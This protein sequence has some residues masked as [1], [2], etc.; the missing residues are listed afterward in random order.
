MKLSV[1]VQ[2]DRRR[3]HLLAALDRLGDRDIVTDP[4]PEQRYGSCLR[5]YLECLRRTPAG[6]THR[7]VVQDDAIPCQRFRALA[8]AAIAEHPDELVALF[9]PGRTLLRKLMVD[10]HRRGGRWVML[11]KGLNWTPTVA[12]AWPARLA[13]EF[14]PHGEAVIAARAARGMGTFADDPY[15]GGWRKQLG[16]QVWATVP[17]LVEHPDVEQSLYRLDLKPKRG[18]NRSR[19]AAL[20]DD[21]PSRYADR[22]GVEQLAARA[23]HNREVAGSSPAPAT[24]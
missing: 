4:E 23:A 9:V 13:R 7:L 3:A 10:E 19:V 5:T 1:C 21:D 14:V 17:C 12:L 22:S 11:P 24:A 18:Q 6:A 20:Y 8:E 2:H 15:V 16:I